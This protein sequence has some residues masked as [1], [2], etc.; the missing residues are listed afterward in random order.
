MPHLL[1]EVSNLM[2]AALAYPASAPVPSPS[3]HSRCAE[4]PEG[5]VGMASQSGLW[6]RAAFLP[7]TLE[8]IVQDAGV[9]YD[10]VL[11]EGFRSSIAPKVSVLEIIP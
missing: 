10:L 11:V 3:G 4:R 8:Q 2:I 5:N 1:S 6:R 7:R 9:G